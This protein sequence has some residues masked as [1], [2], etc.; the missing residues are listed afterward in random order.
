MKMF[1][2]AAVAAS[3]AVAMLGAPSASAQERFITIGAG[4]QTGCISWWANRS[5]AW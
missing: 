2:T 5:T 4:G 1:K 3:I